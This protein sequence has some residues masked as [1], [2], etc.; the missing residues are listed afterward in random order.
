MSA[1]SSLDTT[2]NLRNA[3]PMSGSSFDSAALPNRSSDRTK[4][5]SLSTWAAKDRLKEDLLYRLGDGKA[6][7]F[8]LT[9]SRII[10]C[11]HSFFQ[12]H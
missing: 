1:L 10:N 8:Q 4:H 11:F 3:A 7:V 9:I 2:E 5:I 6:T 12:F